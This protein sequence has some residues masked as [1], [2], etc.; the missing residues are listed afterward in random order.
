MKPR[1]V[2]THWIHDEVADYLGSSCDL[3]L[4]QTRLTLPRSVIT[5][6]TEG[7]HAIMVFMP[8]S[9]DEEF[10]SACPNLKVVAAALKGYDNFDVDACTRRGIWFTIV[11]DLLT[12]PTAELAIGL[13][14]SLTRRML[15]GDRLV[16]T[17][18]FAGWRPQLYGTGLSGACCG[19]IGLGAVGRALAK[20]LKGFDVNV[21]YSDIVPLPASEEEAIGVRR[22]SLED[23]LRNSDFVFPLVPLRP[24]TFYLINRKTLLLMKKGAFLINVCRGSVVNEEDVADALRCGQIAGYAA[25]VFEMEDWARTERPSAISPYLIENIE[26]TFFTPHLGSAVDSVRR[27][28]AMEAARNI[29]QGLNGEVPMGAVNG[30]FS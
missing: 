15:E 17:G 16:R 24:S 28:I 23:L 14:L 6:R 20:R 29:I 1:V 18:Q 4:N 10:L 22:V 3:L 27:E 8:D 26:N 25:D 19:I 5:E 7:A 2:V 9:L 13:L 21:I 30:P 11:H 12:V